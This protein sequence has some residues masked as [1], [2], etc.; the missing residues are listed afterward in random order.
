MTVAHLFF[1][2]N[3]NT[4]QQKSFCIMK[5]AD[6]TSG[7]QRKCHFYLSKKWEGVILFYFF[8]IGETRRSSLCVAVL[9]LIRLIVTGC[10]CVC[11]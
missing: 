1:E 10:G 11:V 5:K 4:L 7:S 3:E 6:E 9:Y 2:N 8:K